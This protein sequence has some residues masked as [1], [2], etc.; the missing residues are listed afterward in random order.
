MA[1]DIEQQLRGVAGV[2]AAAVDGDRVHVL[3]APGADGRAVRQAAEPMLGPGMRLV[4][5]AP[6]A[7]GGPGP[8]RA[9]V[10]DLAPTFAAVVAAVAVAGA[11]SAVLSRAL[12]PGARGGGAGVTA[13]R[14]SVQDEAV[15]TVVPAAEP[16][17]EVLGSVVER[18]DL[19]QLIPPIPDTP[20]SA[21]TIPLTD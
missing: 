2:L 8:V 11:G 14:S 1:G 3:A 21:P 5:L 7:G 19:G 6:P 9:V 10:A 20:R 18:P 13:T 16:R 12:S 4:V 17:T 15:R